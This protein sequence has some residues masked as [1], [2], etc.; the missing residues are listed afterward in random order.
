[1]SDD[2]LPYYEKELAFIR[3]SGAEFAEA[4]PKIAGR[5]RINSDTVED[6]HVSRLLEGF[7]Y[8]NARVQHKLDDEFPELTDALFN[9]VYP[10]YLRP[11]PSCSIIQFETAADLDSRFLIE[12]DTLMESDA[13]QG[14]TCKFTTCYD[15]DLVPLAI[16][17]ASLQ[18]RPFIAP[19]ANNIQNAGAIIH[20]GLK[21]LSPK[22]AA[23][24]LEID[25][26]RFFL[27]G[28]PQHV[29]PIHRMLL[30]ESVK[31]VVAR[32]EGDTNPVY[33]NVDRIKPVG[34]D[35]NQG[36][37]PYPAE[38]FVGYRLLTEYFLFPEKFHFIDIDLKGVIDES[39]DQEVNLYIYVEHSNTELERTLST[40]NFAL[41]CTPIVNLFSHQADPMRVT[42]TQREYQ[43][44]PDARAHDSLE[45]YSVDNVKATLPSGDNFNYL[46]FYGLHHDQSQSDQ[47]LY[48]YANRKKASLSATPEHEGTEV[49]LTLT[50]LGFSPQSSA[51][52]TLTIKTTCLNRDLPSKL[53]FG[54]GQ[55][56]L[57]CVEIAP[58][59]K[60]VACL[61][62]PTHTVQPDLRNRARWRLLSHLN[63][64]HLTLKNGKGS[65]ESVKELLR[66]YNFKESA[67]IRTII[68]ALESVD[69]HY[70]TAP[71]TV[72][73]RTTLCRGT[74][75]TLEFNENQLAGTS[76]FLFASVMEHFFGVYCSVNSFTRLTAKIKGKDGVLKTWPPRAGEKSLL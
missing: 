6:P 63:L 10:H 53:P 29:Y 51:Q 19:G 13:F 52:Q 60:G 76:A 36:L 7:A 23:G 59:I 44:I 62:P 64:N 42:H 33:L 75:I 74:Q 17:S 14:K 55:P 58:P 37:I 24:N 45:I 48:W 40:D 73:G 1:M 5:L 65:T 67:A 57:H 26:L 4:H 31:L 50:D 9:I 69:S 15:T 34:Y 72:E 41:G 30:N 68:E 8:L 18:A 3:K 46:P 71:I 2:L 38:S 22:V 66:L 54:G 47:G 28:Q 32:S 27:K 35:E 20:L 70:M 11:F 21:T 43:I 56:R 39:F 25:S 49:Y 61:T 12:K 16:N